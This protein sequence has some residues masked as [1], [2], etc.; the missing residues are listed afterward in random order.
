MIGVNHSYVV[1]P[2]GVGVGK[3]A[4]FRI[5][6]LP[7]DYPDE[8]IVWS[9]E[10]AGAVEF[11][12]GNT[13]RAVT[14]RGVSPGT[15]HL[16]IH[17]GDSPSDPPH[18][19]LKVVTNRVFHVK[20]WVARKGDGTTARNASEIQEM[21]GVIN[22]IYAQIGVSFVFEPVG[23]IDADE[24]FKVYYYDVNLI[25]PDDWS[26]QRLY[27]SAWE[28]GKINTYFIASFKEDSKADTL[29]VYFNGGIVMTVAANARVLA[30]ELGHHMGAED[31]YDSAGI[32]L[33]VINIPF[34]YGFAPMDWSNGCQNTNPGYYGRDVTCDRIISRLLM[35]GEVDVSNTTS[36]D[37][38]SG[39][40]CGV[41]NTS[42]G[43]KIIG[44]ADVGLIN[45]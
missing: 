2:C 13:G 11:V 28:S 42:D 34:R 20:P 44:D 41:V 19:P 25:S 39:D 3:D 21:I 12:G 40:V 17:I 16:S 31:V 10:T 22:D 32:Q 9:N 7:S 26:R 35:N 30:H 8:K 14:V 24:T 18:F 27:D 23:Y 33:S 5:Q 38:T 37:I 29:A 4:Y 36:I 45:K 6:V 15:T 43:G 1:N